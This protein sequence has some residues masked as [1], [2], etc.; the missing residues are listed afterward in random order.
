MIN[1]RLILRLDNIL[2][3]LT[4]IEVPMEFKDLLGLV[5]KSIENDEKNDTL[6]FRTEDRKFI[7]HHDQD[8]CESVNLEEVIGDLNDLL[9]QP[10]LLAEE[11]TSDENPKEEY[12]ESFTWTFYKLATNKGY[13]TLRWY[14]ASNGYYS[15]KIDFD[16]VLHENTEV[17]ID[18]DYEKLIKMKEYD[19]YAIIRTGYKGR[20]A[21]IEWGTI[22][23][24]MDSC[25]PRL[26][27][28]FYR[29]VLDYLAPLL[30]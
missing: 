18:C 14:G 26:D 15:E 27:E 5:L 30:D 9:D 11:V 3:T 1:H 8:C 10:I 4:L 12:D 17:V 29:K 13:V 25:I 22:D 23:E 20:V 16:E 7:M 21:P 2:I 24:I 19:Y 28:S 6:I